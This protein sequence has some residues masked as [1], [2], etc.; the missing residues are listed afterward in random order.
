MSAESGPF[1][2]WILGV[3]LRCSRMTRARQCPSLLWQMGPALGSNL[4]P[5]PWRSLPLGQYVL[6]LLPFR[7]GPDT[8]A[9]PVERIQSGL[10]LSVQRNT[11]SADPYLEVSTLHPIPKSLC[12]DVFPHCLQTSFRLHRSLLLTSLGMKVAS[13]ECV[14]VVS[15]LQATDL[16][17]SLCC[18]LY[19][20]AIAALWGKWLRRAKQ[21]SYN[22]TLFG[23]TRIQSPSTLPH[24]SVPNSEES[25]MAQ[26][27]TPS[28]LICSIY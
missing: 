22:S 16:K 4:G 9:P 7:R 23:Q 15:Y 3:I 25:I 21:S 28:S 27:P 10:G 24:I 11:L 1:S 17:L 18:G 8:A 20:A 2:H 12:S 6:V 26:R 13:R 5:S 19:S 14:D